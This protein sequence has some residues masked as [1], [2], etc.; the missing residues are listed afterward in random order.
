MKYPNLGDDD[1]VDLV[2]HKGSG[3]A[4]WCGTCLFYAK[5]GEPG[6]CGKGAAAENQTAQFDREIPRPTGWGGWGFCDSRCRQLEYEDQMKEPQLK[7]IM[8]KIGSHEECRDY[9]GENVL[10]T[11]LCLYQ[12]QELD[13]QAFY[14]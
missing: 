12:E 7:E 10:V 1:F 14:K 13:I 3:Q 9:F 6:Y 8:R 2:C 11:R 4:G 5:K